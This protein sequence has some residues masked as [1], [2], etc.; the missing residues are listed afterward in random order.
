M[1]GHKEKQFAKLDT[2][3][4]DVIRSYAND[5]EDNGKMK[6]HLICDH[7]TK[8]L[9][10]YNIS[11]TYVRRCLEE[12]YKDIKQSQN[13]KSGDTSVTNVLELSLEKVKKD[14]DK[15]FS[16]HIRNQMVNSM[17]IDIVK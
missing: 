5:L 9:K 2:K 17:L 16:W 8:A 12:K 13:R 6:L 11:G 3:K 1:L 15:V 14:V 7:V 10:E 4:K